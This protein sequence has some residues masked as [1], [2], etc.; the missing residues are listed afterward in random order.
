MTSSINRTPILNVTT[1]HPLGLPQGFMY[2][3]PLQGG[4]ISQGGCSP[5]STRDRARKVDQC[6]SWQQVEVSMG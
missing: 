3:I 6:W 4:S 5:G 2:Q 1:L